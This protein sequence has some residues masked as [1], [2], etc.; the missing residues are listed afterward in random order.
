M[1][2][3]P[4]TMNP[5]VGI[6]FL[7]N[8]MQ[9]GETAVPTV[10]NLNEAEEW[11]LVVEGAHHGGT[12]GHPF[13]IHE[14]SFEVISLSNDACPMPPGMIMDTLW[15]PANTTAVIRLKFKQWTGKSVFHC[16]ILPHED[17][18]MMQNFLIV[19]PSHAG[20]H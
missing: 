14:V 3:F 16:H 19:D 11:S 17:T 18:G 15:V 20:R 4:G 13:H 10:I 12:E 7:I 2:N 9:Y 1:G 6:D 5:Y 8:N